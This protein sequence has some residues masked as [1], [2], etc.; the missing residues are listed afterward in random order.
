MRT[1]VRVVQMGSPT[2]RLDRRCRAGHATP[3]PTIGAADS[4]T[5]GLVYDG[6]SDWLTDTWLG[7]S[8]PTIDDDFTWIT[9]EVFEIPAGVCTNF[10]GTGFDGPG[11]YVEQLIRFGD[12]LCWEDESNSANVGNR[13]LVEW[14]ADCNGDGIV[15][16]GQILDG[17]F[18]DLD[19]NG[20]PDCCENG[21]DCGCRVDL[22]E[23]GEV[24]TLDFLLYLGAWSQG[25]PLA[26]WDGNGAINTLDFLAYLNG[27]SIGC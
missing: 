5:T 23:D 21:G 19:G 26:D 16:Y 3:H 15:D 9:G 6:T 11:L 7:A 10:N 2:H 1:C 8:R 27:W 22:T 17:T 24:N 20:V 25:D 12:T 14:S 4:A 18:E 13:W